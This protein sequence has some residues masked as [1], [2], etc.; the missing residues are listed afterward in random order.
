LWNYQES[1][2]MVN[3]RLFVFLLQCKE[4]VMLLI[5]YKVYEAATRLL[6]VPSY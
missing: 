3:C 1:N 6:Y 4:D 2:L 5:S